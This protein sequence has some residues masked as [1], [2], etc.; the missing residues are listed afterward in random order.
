MRCSAVIEEL[1]S[2]APACFAESWD[3]PGLLTGR[4][5]KA[6]RTVMLAVD[7]TDS[8]VEEAAERGADLLV[9]HPPNP[10]V[11][12]CRLQWGPTLRRD[13]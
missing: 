8:V 9:T 11:R 6:V 1:E 2:L 13:F 5:E 4:F 10:A 12:Q 7:A 3:N